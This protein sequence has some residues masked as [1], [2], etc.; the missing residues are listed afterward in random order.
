MD[1]LSLYGC[2]LSSKG[3]GHSFAWIYG[4]DSRQIKLLYRLSAC[5]GLRSLFSQKLENIINYKC[6]VSFL[7]KMCAKNSANSWLNFTFST[8]PTCKAL[9]GDLQTT[10]QI[11]KYMSKFFG[12][13]I[14]LGKSEILLCPILPVKTLQSREFFD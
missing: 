14:F 5:F 13:L 2:S 4:G 1:V 10:V 8:I 3:Q 6:T 7:S 11:W 9:I 12:N